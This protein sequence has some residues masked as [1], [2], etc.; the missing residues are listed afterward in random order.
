MTKDKI[1]FASDM[2]LGSAIL[3]NA[4]ETEKRL[5]RWLDIIKEDAKVLYLL[6]DVFDFWF[7]YKKV[8]PKGFVRFLGKLAELHDQ[9]TEIH[10]FT[11]NHDIWTFNYLSREIGVVVHKKPWVTEIYGKKFFL[12]HGD[13]LGDESVS[14]RLL[15]SIFHNRF[16]QFLFAQLPSFWGMS[17]GHWWS[18]NNRQ[19]SLSQPTPYLGE[20]NEHLARFAK[21]YIIGHPDTDYLLFGH[22]HILLDLMLNQKSRMMIL[23]D[24]MHYF[25]YAVFDGKEIFLKQ[26]EV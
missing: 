19:K 6:G 13:G 17:F 12:A 11:G 15:R 5:V 16:C 20:E 18:R 14:F 24:W 10:F 25:S 9:G 1:Y 21:Q 8:V 26:F 2:H 7:E 23:G 3:E 22:R 4:L